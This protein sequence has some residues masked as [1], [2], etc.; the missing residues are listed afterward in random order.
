MNEA[1]LSARRVCIATFTMLALA[2]ASAAPVV[3]PPTGAA[4]KEAAARPASTAC[5]DLA[6]SQDR[7]SCLK[8]MAAAKAETRHG[9]LGNGEDAGTLAR[10][11]LRRCEAVQ[12]EDRNACER[13]ARGEG[14]MS[15]SVAGGGLL[16]SITTPVAAPGT[17]PAR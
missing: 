6:P 12:P 13:M 17:P 10:N 8:E 3:A 11:A 1:I 15:G 4:G 9:R 7:Q 14:E 5:A 16:K 2:S